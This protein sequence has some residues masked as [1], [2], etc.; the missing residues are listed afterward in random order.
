MPVLDQFHGRILL[1][2]GRSASGRGPPGLTPRGEAVPG[3]RN[4]RRSGCRLSTHDR[5]DAPSSPR[6]AAAPT[7]R[8]PRCG[9]PSS[10]TARRPRSTAPASS[11]SAARWPASRPSRAVADRRPRRLP[12]LRHPHPLTARRR[13]STDALSSGGATRPDGRCTSGRSP[14]AARCQR[15]VN[16]GAR[17]A[18]NAST[19]SRWS[20][21]CP[22]C[23]CSRRLEGQRVLQ[24]VRRRRREH[25]LHRPVGRRRAR[26]PAA[27]PAPAPPASTCSGGTTRCTSPHCSARLREEGLGQ[28]Q[29]LRGPRR[30]RRSAPAATASAESLDSPIPVN[31]VVNFAPAAATRRSPASAM[32]SPAP[33]QAPLMPTTT[34]TRSAASAR[35]SGLYSSSTTDRDVAA[36]PRSDSTCSARSWPTQKARPCRSAGPR[37]PTRPRRRPARRRAVPAQRRGQAGRCRVMV[38]TPPASVLVTVSDIARPASLRA[39]VAAGRRRWSRAGHACHAVAPPSTARPVSSAQ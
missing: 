30:R 38:A 13:T 37:A 27:P 20:A 34:G 15:P 31:A 1:R 8:P 11:P 2:S 9:T 18:R 16:S 33:A 26:T 24:R 29:Q 5:A 4:P 25:R 23:V 21:V 14:A 19:A 32:P 6:P 22:S 7:A 17:L 3:S 12:R 36:L 39:P 35:T 28:Q 10:C